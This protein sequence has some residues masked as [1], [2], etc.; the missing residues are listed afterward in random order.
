MVSYRYQYRYLLSVKHYDCGCP[1]CEQTHEPPGLPFAAT[2]A[3]Y[4][5]LRQFLVDKYRARPFDTSRITNKL[6]HGSGNGLLQPFQHQPFPMM[7]GT[8]LKIFLHKDA[9]P[10]VVFQPGKVP[11]HWEAK[12]KKDLDRD[13]ALG[14]LEK[15][16]EN[17]PMAWCSENGGLQEAQWG[18]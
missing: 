13:V 12:V 16:Q 14:V 6:I 15:V 10:Y 11:V 17:N 9:R 1:V 4:D 8:S 5:N 18:P 7:Q 3:N 2:E